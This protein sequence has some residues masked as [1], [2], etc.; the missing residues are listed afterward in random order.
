MMFV[1]TIQ[2]KKPLADL[3]KE[4]EFFYLPPERGGTISFIHGNSRL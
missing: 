3:E 2:D 4:A 1:R